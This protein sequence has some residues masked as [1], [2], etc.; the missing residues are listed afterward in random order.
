MIKFLFGDKFS[1]KTEYFSA[2]MRAD[3][4]AGKLSVLIVPEQQA[5]A[6][7][8]HTLR[9]LPP[10]AQLTLEVLNFS[11]LYNRVC[12]EY[13]GLCYSYISKPVKN[14]LMWK[15]LRDTVPFLNEYAENARSDAS[16]A[17]TMLDCISELKASCVSV[18]MLESAAEACKQSNP[19]LH[20]RL[21]DIA[22]LYGT[23]D[24]Y[25]NRKYTDSADDLSR[26]CTIL[27]EHNFFKNKNVYIDSFSSFTAVE[28][29][30][31][32]RIFKTADNV[33][34]SI[35]LPSPSYSDISTASIQ[36]SFKILKRNA[37]RWGECE[38]SLLPSSTDYSPIRYLSEHLWDFTSN[39]ATDSLP[40]C[41][42]KIVMELCN[43]SYSEAEATASHILELMRKGAR[44]R[45]IVVIMRNAD[46]YKGIIE[47]AFEKAGVP[48]YV[49][50][51]T[52]I[53][54]LAPIKFILS[55]LRIKLYN[56]RK[57]D[58]ISHIKTGLCDFPL[59][60]ADVFEEYINTWNINGSRF[61]DGAW[62]MNPD[63]FTERMS[64]R[65]RSILKTANEVRDKLSSQ[66]E[67][68]FILLEAAQ[69][70]PDMCRA[71]YRYIE[72]A[73]L[74]EKTNELAKKELSYG[75]KKAA[76]ELAGIYD[77]ILKALAEIGE[78]LDDT[79]CSV[80]D[81]GNILKAVFDNTALGTIPT[82]VDEVTIGSASLLRAQNPEYVFVLGLCDGEFPRNIEDNGI[83]ASADRSALS[84]LDI[85]LGENDE[86][87]Y[88]QELMYV[89]NAFCAPNKCLY[90]LSSQNTLDGSG[91]T[92]SLPFKRAQ[93]LFCDLTPHK[94]EEYD[95]SYLCGTPR[96][97]A[98]HLKNIVSD[99]DRIAAEDAVCDELPLV[100]TQKYLLMS[101]TECRISAETARRLIGERVYISPSSLEKYV[102]CPF[103]YY[104]SYMLSLRE[105][106]Y[107]RFGSNQMGSF[108]HYMMEHIVRFAVPE[109]N[110]EP[111][112]DMEQIRSEVPNIVCE[113]ISMIAPDNSL[114]TKRMEHL[115]GKLTR[116]SLFIAE[117]VCKELSDS[118][119]RPAFFELHIDGKNGNPEPV[120]IPLSNGAALVLKGYIDRVDI[121]R[122]GDHVYVRIVDYKTGSM[123]FSLSELEYGLNTQMLLYLFS[124]CTSPG[125]TFRKMT[126]LGDGELPLPAGVV[127]LS[128]AISKSPLERFDTTEEEIICT[129][130]QKLVRSGLILD[131]AQVIRAI[132]HSASKDILMGVTQ[133]DGHFVGKPLISGEALSELFVQLRTTLTDIGE[134]IYSG[135]AD[136]EPNTHTGNDPCKFCIAKPMCRK[137]NF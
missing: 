128:A 48:F 24:T 116:L 109:T 3:A 51:K 130:E 131:E 7:E 55:A 110:S 102:L 44:C 66:L 13:G 19:R 10:Y 108:V 86:L 34:I 4:E 37:A 106:K 17:D 98:A 122:D 25:V 6:A 78:A 59:R 104:A 103:G 91:R 32:E 113:Y 84:E 8:H 22:L 27:D 57:N 53:C 81:F 61:C 105:K 112:L 77:T 58:I 2:L 120:E 62:S 90:L 94:Y 14:V 76:A 1:N 72:K 63:G 93:R 42:G 99:S 28:H 29:R 50:E 70:V 68:F 9:E 136:C 129:A 39:N 69:N 119:F 88:S 134:K 124:L 16:F 31:I 52:D 41:Q 43:D 36:N 20:S 45:D 127:Y 30:V 123:T 15:V 96:S 117:N 80:E 18:N 75:N 83:F 23:Y 65:G 5:V 135:I 89:K 85:E 26:L 95:L 21:C 97:A 100:R 126:S 107:G 33:F 46:K 35:P 82:S 137:N 125:Y 114:N 49:S 101:T 47:P 71:V 40:S 79:E 60:S 132:S 92:P 54:S 73:G 38:T 118:D 87:K 133:R 67:E 56:W 121:W 115:Y 64:E 12:R 74:R 11:R 111:L